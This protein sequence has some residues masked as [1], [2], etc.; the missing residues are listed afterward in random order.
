MYKMG[1]HNTC[2]IAF[3]SDSNDRLPFTNCTLSDPSRRAL[4]CC[5]SVRFEKCMIKLPTNRDNIESTWCPFSMSICWPSLRRSSHCTGGS[6]PNWPNAIKS[7]TFS[8]RRAERWCCWSSSMWSRR[9]L[10]TRRFWYC[11]MKRVGMNGHSLVGKPEMHRF[12]T[13]DDAMGQWE[14]KKNKAYETKTNK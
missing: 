3:R 11:V 12:K 4:T 7:L 14:K 5:D 10:R 6:T 8:A 13:T 2:N 9:V 1:R